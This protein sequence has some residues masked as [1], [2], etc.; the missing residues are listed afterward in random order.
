MADWVVIHEPAPPTPGAARA[1][2]IGTSHIRVD[3]RDATD[4]AKKAIDSYRSWEE[5]TL[6]AVPFSD[7]THVAVTKRFEFRE[8]GPGWPQPKE[9]A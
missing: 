7:L 3:A 4:A 8:H 2:S 1:T 6:W 5:G 9:D